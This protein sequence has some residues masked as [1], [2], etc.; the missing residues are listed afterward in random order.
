MVTLQL[1]YSLR[2]AHLDRKMQ[3]DPDMLIRPKEVQWIPCEVNFHLQFTL[4]LQV[5]AL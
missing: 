2:I 1:V 5:V 4:V 3:L